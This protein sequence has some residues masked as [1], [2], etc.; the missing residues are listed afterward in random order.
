[1]PITRPRTG[2]IDIMHKKNREHAIRPFNAS[3]ALARPLRPVAPLWGYFS[4]KQ[5]KAA[6]V[7]GATRGEPQ[8][9][10]GSLVFVSNNF[11]IAQRGMEKCL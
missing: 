9:G 4:Q 10:G 6:Y 11:S 3:L 8:S 1:M 7:V 5:N 2:V